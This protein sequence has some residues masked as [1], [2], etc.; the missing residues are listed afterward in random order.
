VQPTN[1]ASSV[2]SPYGILTAILRYRRMIVAV[3]AACVLVSVG[4]GLLRPREYEATALF[5]PEAGDPGISDATALARQFGINLGRQG[6][7]YSSYFYALLIETRE[8][9]GSVMSAE[10][11]PARSDAVGSLW[12][13]WKVKDFERGVRALRRNLTVRVDR[14]TEVVS[15]DVRNRDPAVS[16]QILG[17]IL[18]Q[19]HQFNLEVRRSQAQAEAQFV[20]ERLAEAQNELRIA[21][22]SLQRFLRRNRQFNQSPELLFEHDRLQREVGLRQE[23]VTGMHRSMEQARIDAVRDTP[24]LTTIATGENSVR[25]VRRYLIMRLIVGGLVGLA[26]GFLLAVSAYYFTRIRGQHEEEYLEFSRLR[27][28]A[29]ESVPLARRVGRS[30]AEQDPAR[31]T[32]G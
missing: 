24:V 27:S 29:L 30:R 20:Q 23:I 16:E 7:G 12:E 8:L 26:L 3:S 14:V 1:N 19:L 21:E 22:D 4:W 11:R 28:E 25:P 13:L 18:A 10:Y 31:G 6:S 32:T 5:V 17:H 15:V 9:L 2:V